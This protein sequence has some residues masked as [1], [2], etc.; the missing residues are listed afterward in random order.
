M[1]ALVGPE[2][3]VLGGGGNLIAADKGARSAH[4]VV[5]GRMPDHVVAVCAGQDHTLIQLHPAGGRCSNWVSIGDGIVPVVCRCHLN[6]ARR[7][8]SLCRGACDADA[9]AVVG[10]LSVKLHIAGGG[11]LSNSI[12]SRKEDVV[13]CRRP[14][15]AR[16]CSGCAASVAAA[17][18]ATSVASAIVGAAVVTA[19]TTCTKHSRHQDRGCDFKGL[20]HTVSTLS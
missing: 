19:T 3:C 16:A 7:R 2:L 1:D 9:L 15:G 12:G 10:G 14:R 11:R 6:G 17:V 20:F 4:G 8:V 13:A 5:D 18:V